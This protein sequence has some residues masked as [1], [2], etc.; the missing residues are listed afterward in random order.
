MKQPKYLNFNKN[1]PLSPYKNAILSELLI[2]SESLH[3]TPF[4][5]PRGEL[6][7]K[8]T[9]THAENNLVSIIGLKPLVPGVFHRDEGV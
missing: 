4:Q 2:L 6:T 1:K 3:S 5:N 7:N 9:Y 8:W